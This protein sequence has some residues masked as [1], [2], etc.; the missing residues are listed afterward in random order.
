MNA[1]L[2]WWIPILGYEPTRVHAACKATRGRECTPGSI[3]CCDTNGNFL[4]TVSSCHVISPIAVVSPILTKRQR[5]GYCKAGDCLHHECKKYSKDI[6]SIRSRRPLT[7]FCGT[8]ESNPCKA[9]CGSEEFSD[10][11]DTAMFPD[12]GEHLMDSAICL[13]DRQKGAFGSRVGSAA[14]SQW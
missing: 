1:I 3:A 11:E 6:K 14:I 5:L 12:G 8:S 7:R 9:S 10:C 4:T 2:K 13:K